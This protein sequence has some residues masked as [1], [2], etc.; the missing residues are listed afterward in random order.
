M[1]TDVALRNSDAPMGYFPPS[2]SARGTILAGLV[3]LALFFGGLGTWAATAPLNAAVVGEAVVKVAGNRKSVQHINGGIVRE[4]LVHEG[5]RVGADQVLLV[6][7]NTEARAEYDLITQQVATLQAQEARLVAERD[8]TASIAFAPDLLARTNDAVA[9]AAMDAQRDEF[10][11][12]RTA[13]DGQASILSQRLFQLDDQI[14]AGEQLLQSQQVQLQSVRDERASLDD[15]FKKGLVTKPRMLQLERTATGLEGQIATTSGQIATNRKAADEI[16]AQI[17]QLKS[18]QLAEVTGKLSETQAKLADLGPRLTNATA[19]LGRMEIRAP[20][21]GEVVDL[22]VFAVGAVI[23]PGERILDIVPDDTLLVVEA[24]VRVEDIAD[25]APGMKGE[26]HFT[27]YKQ[28]VT[29]LI[30]G[31][32]RSVSADRLTDERTQIPYYV[33][34]IDVDAAELAANP[35]IQLYPGMPATVSITTKERT[36]LDYLIG[37]LTASLERSFREK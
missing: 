6:L 16:D 24:R 28:R 26:V 1:S 18:D 21:A 15:L 29:P 35:E 9:I 3:I 12:R 32:V 19:S 31:S 22:A 25:I 30:H 27:S 17:R 4:L 14:T 2:D 13:L 11:S 5:D 33:A 34:E 36:A 8:G 37:P 7:D 10:D 20:Y 23:G